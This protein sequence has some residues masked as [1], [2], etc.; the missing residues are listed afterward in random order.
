MESYIRLE[1][2]WVT[3]NDAFIKIWS[4][5]DKFINNIENMEKLR[6][7]YLIILGLN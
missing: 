6:K 1:G 3:K 7:E 2:E 4:Q 5:K